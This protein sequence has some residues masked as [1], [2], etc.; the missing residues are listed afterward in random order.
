MEDSDSADKHT[1]KINTNKIMTAYLQFFNFNCGRA[2]LR[3]KC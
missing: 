1:V 2:F 3:L